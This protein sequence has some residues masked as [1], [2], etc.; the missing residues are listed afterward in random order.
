MCRRFD[1]G[2]AD[3]LSVE[4][5][6]PVEGVRDAEGCGELLGGREGWDEQ[7]E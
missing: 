1:F 3:D 6:E 7:G 4:R 5:V 2:D